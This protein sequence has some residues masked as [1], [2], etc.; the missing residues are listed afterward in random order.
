MPVPAVPPAPRHLSCHLA[1]LNQLFFLLAADAF[2]VTGMFFPLNPTLLFQRCFGMALM[3]L[4][5]RSFPALPNSRA[6]LCPYFSMGLARPLRFLDSFELSRLKAMLF[7]LKL[8]VPK[9][10]RGSVIGT[11][12]LLSFCKGLS[13][14]KLGLF[15][16]FKPGVCKQ[17]FH[18]MKVSTLKKRL[19]RTRCKN[20]C[21]FQIKM[22][23][24][25]SC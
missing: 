8:P 13:F 12:F 14:F 18:Y 11:G 24:A 10:Y 20:K 4:G 22:M 6:G 16:L 9:A 17:L 19:I 21:E 25:P 23:S 2:L 1:V 3:A 15:R 5:T 7:P